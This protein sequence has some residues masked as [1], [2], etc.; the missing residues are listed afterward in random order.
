MACASQARKNNT[1][2]TAEFAADSAVTRYGVISAVTEL[3]RFRGISNL[4][5]YQAHIGSGFPGIGSPPVALAGYGADAASES[6]AKRIAIAEAL[7]RYSAGDFLGEERKW[8][9]A[10][11]LSGEI[12]DLESIARCSDREYADPRCPFVRPDPDAEIRWVRGYNL[13]TGDPAW[14]PAVMACYTINDLAPQERFWYQISTGYAVHTDPAEA[15]VRGA[16]EVIERDAIALIWLQKLAP[17]QLDRNE[18]GPSSEAVLAEV[19]QLLS[20]GERH[21]INTYL[22][23]ATTDLR[24]PIVYC[25]QIAEYDDLGHQLVGCAA[26]RSLASAARKAVQEAVLIRTSFYPDDPVPASPEEFRFLKDGGR[27]MGLPERQGAFEFLFSEG[28]GRVPHVEAQSLPEDPAEALD[29]LRAALSAKDMSAFVI[30]RTTSELAEVGLTAVNVVIPG[31]QPMSL[32][33]FGK[34]LNHS[35]LSQA[36]R[37]MGIAPLPEESMNPWPQ[38]FM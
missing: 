31:L 34:F 20:W 9:R 3:P 7:E 32:K 29:V 26:S 2:S 36:P 24:I 27:Y 15:I 4:H 22:F 6:T 21:F 5:A 37:A 25:L 28:S 38:P 18:I 30:D 33:P 23:N 10:S 11:E 1:S 14:V 17:P 19:D 13:M 8:A 16:L 12:L 35:R